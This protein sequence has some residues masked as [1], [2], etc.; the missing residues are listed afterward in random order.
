MAIKR[1]SSGRYQIDFRD[2]RGIRH[3]E[4]YRLCKDAERALRDKKTKVDEGTFVAR[5]A[6]PTFEEIAE[7]WYK[8]KT[9]GVG[10]KKVP[11]PATLWAWRIHLDRHLLPELKALRVNRIDVATMERVRD[12]L[13]GAGLGPVTVNKVLVTASAIFRRA[14]K[15]NP[16]IR[17]P[18]ADTD[19]LG[20]GNDEIT[21]GESRRR[22]GA[23][24]PEGVLSPA[25]I[26][27]LIAV[28]GPDLYGT[29]VLTAIFTGARHDELLALKWGVIDFA[30][31][32]I[33]IKE[34][35]TWARLNGEVYTERWRFYPP[36]TTAG[37]RQIEMAS[38]LVSRL[39]AW[40]LRCP[41]SR[42][43][44]VFPSPSGDPLP[45]D[46]TLRSGLHPLLRRAG[47]RK[48]DMHSLR[49][50][51][52]SMLI[53]QRTP[54][55]EV[56]AILGH[57]HKSTTLEVYTHFFDGA[58]TGAVSRLADTLTAPE[59]GRGHFLDTSEVEAQRGG[60]V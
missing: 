60:M 54:I 45:R 53:Q 13:V 27:R 36:K 17:N 40:K 51:F 29:L 15:K 25:E 33:W 16:L 11:R 39:K 10:C 1:L 9:Q 28:C 23:V 46:H 56:S 50:S 4:S 38:F 59:R 58:G 52:A 19:R 7:A 32:K 55:N 47:L 49:H 30:V 2:Q 31:G 34:S 3:R 35:I 12:K 20:L 37:L 42:L 5:K 22:G 21:E 8:D 26:R 43:D 14:A 44:L 41:P 57:S 48:V 6:A 24:N 18:A